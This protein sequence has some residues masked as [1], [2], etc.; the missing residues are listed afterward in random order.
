MSW[1]ELME[2]ALQ[3]YI[4]ERQATALRT[5][6]N[7]P[8]LLIEHVRQE[9]SFR[10]GG[11]GTRQV[12]ELL[13]N[14][15]DAVGAGGGT[16]MVELRLADG[17]LYC[18]NE[19]VGFARDGVRA[20]TYAFLSTKRG[21]EIGRFGLGFKSILGITDHPQIYSRSVSF[22]FNAPDTAELF[23]GIPNE[24]G[25]LPLLR[26]PTL[27]DPVRAAAEDPNLAELFSWGTTVVKLPLTR[28][29]D[30]VRKELLE[31]DVEA[32][33]FFKPLDRLRITV[34]E[35]PGAAP[36]SRD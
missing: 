5:Y 21:D 34:Q 7:D 23:A 26:I 8:D 17:A 27:T 29:G 20:V 11:Y 14:A 36:Q 22:E 3:E 13:Q 30:R 2:P 32:L 24:G 15:V 25:R 16:G 9:D 33:L 6:E 28:E 12:S 1:P 10:T 4:E 19:G 18:A 35:S 31:F